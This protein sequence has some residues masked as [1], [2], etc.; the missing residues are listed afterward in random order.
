MML[1]TFHT[2][3]KNEVTEVSSK[4]PNK[5]SIIKPDVVLDYTKYMGVV[6]I[7]DHCIASY[8]FMRR[9]NK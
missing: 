1:S 4:Y 8:Q 5:P 7:S 6:D 9:I 2:G 3:N